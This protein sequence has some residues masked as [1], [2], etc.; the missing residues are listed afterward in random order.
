MKKTLIFCAIMLI[1]VACGSKKDAAYKGTK[2]VDVPCAG[3]EYR[4]DKNHLRALGTGYST[5]LQTARD[6]ALVAARAELGTQVNATIKRV[7]D[8]FA[9]SYEIGMD[10]EAKGKFLDM[11]RQVVAQELVGTIVICDET[12]RTGDG[13]FR[14]Y[15]VV[16]I[17]GTDLVNKIANSVKNDDKLRID[18]E[19]EKFK[20]EFEKE[21]NKLGE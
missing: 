1:A 14:C 5:S 9:S 7:T 10:E 20:E 12:E 3:K 6:K 18:Y 15:V 4:S 17:G 19:Y 21:M 11:T 8:N 16:E 2:A 13:K